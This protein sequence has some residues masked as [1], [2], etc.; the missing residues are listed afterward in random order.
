MCVKNVATGML[1]MTGLDGIYGKMSCGKVLPLDFVM[2][3]ALPESG[4]RCPRCF[5]AA[6]RV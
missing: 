4:P 3:D 5:T 6:R 1:H 2:S